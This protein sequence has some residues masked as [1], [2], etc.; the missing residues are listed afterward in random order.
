MV[1]LKFLR[2]K[3]LNYLYKAVSIFVLCCI[4]SACGGGGGS[5]GSSSSGSG[6]SG[7]TSASPSLKLS[8]VDALDVAVTNNIVTGSSSVYLRAVVKD[9]AG[10]AVK[11]KLVTL[12]VGNSSIVTLGQTT[13]LT[14][15]EGV[16]KVPVSPTTITS[17]GATSL[18]AYA[19][20][21][22]VSVSDV[23]DVGTQQTS[24]SLAN[25]TSSSSSLAPYGVTSVSVDV[26]V[27][28]VLSKTGNVSV[29]FTKTCG[30]FSATTVVPD[31]SGKASTT[32]DSTGCQTSTGSTAILGATAL[33]LTGSAPSISI[34]VAAAVGS[35]LKFV[36]VS[37]SVIYTQQATFG[38]KQAAIKFKLLDS[39]G[40]AV[41]TASS[42]DVS[43]ATAALNSGAT[44]TNGSVTSS[45][46][47]RY[48]TDSNGEITVLVNSGTFPTPLTV[49][50]TLVSNTSIT[51]SS[52]GLVVNSGRP[53]QNFFS[54]SATTYNIEGWNIDGTQTTIQAYVADRLGQPVPTGTQVS[55]ITEGGQI[56]GNCSVVAY[57]N[58]TS[59]CSVNMISQAFRPTDGRVSV[60]AYA[61]GDEPF[62]DNNGNN[63]Y[64]SG[65][66]FTSMGQPYLDKDESG[67]YDAGID[68]LVTNPV[69]IGS[70]ACPVK[71]V[72]SEEFYSS[73]VANTCNST[74]GETLVRGQLVIVFSSS[75]AKLPFTFGAAT[76][77]GVNVTIEDVNGQAM[78][79]D[80]VISAAVGGVSSTVC[81]VGSVTPSKVGNTNTVGGTTHAVV[82]TGSGCSGGTITVTATSP[83]GIQTANAVAIP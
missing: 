59:G 42:V 33:N 23:I 79:K 45:A 58:N 61:E 29:T 65:E 39:G 50:A 83:S 76:P 56:V 34:P 60:L 20:V 63:K 32:F 44:F 54:L 35:S 16:I 52:G 81:S 14:N 77:S 21:G 72:L 78:P 28:G 31:A 8:L 30:A 62:S 53:S 46:T 80:T 48:T 82:L 1:V 57:S 71:A 22:T 64:D 9:A 68:Q 24:V 55:F 37:P 13:G 40:V 36:S 69:G 7:S 73:S 75:Y 51:A 66:S 38:T 11:D 12:Q 18:S 6:S 19:T 5:S 2:E 47:Q 49:A 10:A 67:V 43:L 17:N 41:P 4:V 3:M 25:L 15:T 26:Y 70:S 27:G 74:W